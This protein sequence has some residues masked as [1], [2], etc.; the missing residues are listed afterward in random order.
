MLGEADTAMLDA[1]GP[2]WYYTYGFEGASIPGHERVY[3]VRPGYDPSA[4]RQ[5]LRRDRGAW[6][7]VGNEPNDPYQDNL[8]PAAY[9]AFYQ[10]F[11]SEARR[12]DSTCRLVPAGIAN[13]D[14]EWA[15]AFR[16]A[17]RQAEGEYPPVDA[18]NVHNYILEPER[19]Q[20]DLAEF[21]RRIVA[22]R[23][24]M[25][26]IGAQDTPLWLTEFGALYGTGQD[27]R[28]PQ[29]LEQAAAYMASTVEWLAAGDQVQR[30]A[31]FATRTAGQF[32]GDLYDEAGLLTALGETYRDAVAAGGCE[33]GAP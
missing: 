29:D 30:W 26:E 9:A 33:S 10:R 16:E 17:Y 15:Q 8:S 25:A 23:A 7:I 18:W 32:Y 13:C 24:W 21:Q 28:P 20:L 3:L 19:D 31:W 2:V 4:L 11:V 27:G 22:F 6:W 1:I 12:W 5:A 14:W